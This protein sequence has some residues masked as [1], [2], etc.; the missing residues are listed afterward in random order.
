MTRK[1]TIRTKLAAALAVPLIALTAFAAFQVRGS[2]DTAD[3]VNRQAD[4]AT[5]ATGPAGIVNALE[6]E[7]NFESLRAI[8]FERAVPLPVTSVTQ[9]KRES[10]RAVS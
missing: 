6:N 8:G 3:R 2:F 10:N 9:A 7:R 1:L 5:S 4:L